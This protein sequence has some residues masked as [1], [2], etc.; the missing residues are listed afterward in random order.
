MPFEKGHKHGRKPGTK[1]KNSSLDV[2]RN[3]HEWERSSLKKTLDP[4]QVDYYLYN[5]LDITEL[6][7]ELKLYNYEWKSGSDKRRQYNLNSR[8]K[9][10]KDKEKK[11]NK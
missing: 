11:N 2:H 9:A 6:Y 1:N 8:M 7:D 4:E 10:K 3:H 5:D